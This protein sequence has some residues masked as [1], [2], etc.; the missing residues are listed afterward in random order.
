MSRYIDADKLKSEFDYK[1]IDM[2][3]T[4]AVVHHKNILEIINRQ[5]T[6]DVRENVRGEWENIT[7]Q[8]KITKEIKESRKC[9]VCGAVYLRHYGN[10]EGYEEDAPNYCPNCGADMRG[11]KV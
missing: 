3:K 4:A 5:P 1:H 7:L 10:E 9:S 2:N 11:G 8:H 6:A